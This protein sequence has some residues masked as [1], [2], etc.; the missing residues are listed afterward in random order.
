[1]FK[2]LLP[3]T[4]VLSGL[5][6]G[7]AHAEF[8][9][10]DWKTEGDSLA[11]I[12]TDTNLE[13]MSLTQTDGMSIAEVQ[14]E[15]ALGADG[16]FEGWRLPTGAEVE[17]MMQNMYGSRI[18]EGNSNAHW[19][20]KQTGIYSPFASAF[21]WTYTYKKTSYPAKYEYRSYALYTDESGEIMMSGVRY[22]NAPKPT[23][24][25]YRVYDTWL[26]EDH[27]SDSYTEDFTSGYYGVFLVSDGGFTIDS[28]DKNS[29]SD[30]PMP[31]IA[32]F[33]LLGLMALRRRK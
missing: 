25:Q 4:F 16:K 6:A 21:G 31:L 23:Q 30:V 27:A 2:K 17:A 24:S 22:L 5:M 20:S 1:M 28:P 15:L 12:D 7:Q 9:K 33:P 26:Y 11:V 32:A 10:M 19:N 3:C 13:W 29:T 18:V 8:V 14:A